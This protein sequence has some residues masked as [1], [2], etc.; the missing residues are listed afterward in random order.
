MVI[1]AK[2]LFV[3]GVW[4][5]YISRVIKLCLPVGGLVGWSEQWM[6]CIDPLPAHA[7]STLIRRELC[8]D[9]RDKRERGR[10]KG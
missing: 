2:A 5:D 4:S 7:L 9:L 3:F 8:I 10:E 1:S 6:S